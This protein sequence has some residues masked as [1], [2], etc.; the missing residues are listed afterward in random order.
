MRPGC[1][2]QSFHEAPVVEEFEVSPLE[3]P[4]RHDHQRQRSPSRGPDATIR[5]LLQDLLVAND[6]YLS[7]LPVARTA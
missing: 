1:K 7:R 6:H 4:W 2:Q 3:V 5:E